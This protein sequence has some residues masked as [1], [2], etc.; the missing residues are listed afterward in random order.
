LVYISDFT[1]VPFSYNRIAVP[2]INSGL[3]ID[4]SRALFNAKTVGDTSP[5]VLF[6]IIFTAL[7]L[8]TQV[9][10]YISSFTLIFVDI[11]VNPFAVDLDYLF[12]IK[13]TGNFF[14]LQSCLIRDLSS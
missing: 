10:M 11:D 9:L 2:V 7:F 4:N 6:A 3:L 8:A 14:G 13:T 1:L 5:V 12:F